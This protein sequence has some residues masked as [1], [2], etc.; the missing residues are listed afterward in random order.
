[1]YYLA[2][3]YVLPRIGKYQVRQEIVVLDDFGT[4]SHR[5]VKVPNDEV[6][7][8]DASHDPTGRALDENAAVT[9]KV[10]DEAE[11]SV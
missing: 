5:L 9:V 7:I 1:M 10:D 8:W 6:E 3:N 2:W 11:K 4:N